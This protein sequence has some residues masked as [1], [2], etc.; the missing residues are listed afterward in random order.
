MA[1]GPV[2]GGLLVDTL[3]WRSIFLI[4]I[5]IGLAG[6]VLTHSTVSFLCSGFTFNGSEA[7]PR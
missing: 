2:L 7:I 3:G 5:P 4:N 6:I 1:V